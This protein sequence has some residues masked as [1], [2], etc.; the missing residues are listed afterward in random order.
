MLSWIRMDLKGLARQ[1]IVLITLVQFQSRFWVVDSEYQVLSTIPM[2]MMETCLVKTSST[3]LSYV[4]VQ[5]MRQWNVMT[6]QSTP[7]LVMLRMWWLFPVSLCSLAMLPHSCC[8]VGIKNTPVDPSKI[9]SLLTDYIMDSD[10][11]II[12]VQD[13]ENFWAHSSCRFA[14]LRKEK[15]TVW[16]S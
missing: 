4:I 8:L 16:T 10:S 1:L 13:G 15:H 5:W 3:A 6:R 9:S 2:N 14:H 11:S 7:W 12:W